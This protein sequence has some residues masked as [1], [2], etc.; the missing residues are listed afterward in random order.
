MDNK[1]VERLDCVQVRSY[2][3]YK[4]APYP[5]IL[6]NLILSRIAALRATVKQPIH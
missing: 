6:M 4:F 2:R 1:E 5:F 3:I